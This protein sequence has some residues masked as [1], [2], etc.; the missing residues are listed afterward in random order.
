MKIED[1]VFMYHQ[2]SKYES[3]INKG[4][5][6]ALV[7]RG[8]VMVGQCAR[9]AVREIGGFGLCEQHAREGEVRLGLREAPKRPPSRFEVEMAH[10]ERRDKE[11]TALRAACTA[12]I[13]TY[14][15]MK[16]DPNSWPDLHI[17]YNLA[18]KAMQLG[19]DG[20]PIYVR[21]EKR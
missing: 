11:R 1:A 4:H 7:G 9:K 2:H 13:E 21:G 3:P 18:R 12:L 19:D 20:D 15:T 8:R 16:P 14:E 6:R 10:L 17:A 5:C